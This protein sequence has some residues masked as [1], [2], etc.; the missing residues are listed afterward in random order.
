M[1]ESDRLLHRRT[2]SR[3]TRAGF[4]R[5]AAAAVIYFFLT[6]F[7]IRKLGMERYGVWS[8]N[9][10][11]SSVF[12]MADF[13]F[14]NSLVHFTAKHL[15]DEDKLAV[16][17]N[18]IFFFLAV[19]AASCL[20]LCVSCSGWI[21]GSLL[22]LPARCR[23]EAIAV[24]TATGVALS[25]R[26]L[27]A[28]Y[29]A[30]IEGNQRVE[31]TQKVMLCW[32]LFNSAATVAALLAVPS[33]YALCV[34]H[35]LGQGFILFLFARRAK[36]DY[37][38]TALERG[39]ANIAALKEVLPYSIWV[40]LAALMIL[41]REPLLKVVVAR[42][43][44]VTELAA[45]EVAYRVTIQCMS[46]AVI[47]LL[48]VLPLSSLLHDRRRELHDVVKRCTVGVAAVLA[49]PL[50]CVYFFSP[51]LVTLWLGEGR[52]N[53]ALMLPAIFAAYC[54]Y[55]LTEP[56]YKTMQ[57]M[58]NS[59]LSAIAQGCFLFALGAALFTTRHR[60]DPAFIGGSIVAACVA[61][62]VLNGFLYWRRVYGPLMRSGFT[63]DGADGAHQSRL[64]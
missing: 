40:Q 13:G 47:P 8:L 26:L 63:A 1:K 20:A 50:V 28:P 34:V 19:T 55:N 54:I 41:A 18:T 45:F 38:Y 39:R 17:F 9:G 46:F 32:L 51:R 61:F 30:V 25:L 43:Y 60:H 5:T 62:S 52:E 56:L 16:L 10:A 53:V 49:V 22:G 36:R 58:G 64:P 21:A 4:V 23:M 48:T 35:V 33:V 31:Y 42:M 2:I 3:T 37:R 15:G 7:I 59:H 24:L 11:V 57:G 44:G 14:Q 6:P 29:Q 12:L 27:A